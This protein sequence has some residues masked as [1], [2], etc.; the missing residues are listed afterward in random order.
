MINQKQKIKAFTLSELIIVILITV[1]VAGIAF[2]VLRLV[3][4]QMYGIQTNFQHTTNVSL[5]EQSLYLDAHRSNRMQYDDLE[6]TLHFISEIDTVR[7]TF[8]KNLV[9]K[10]IDTFHITIDKAQFY[11]E[12]V[13]ATSHRMDAFKLTTAKEFKNATI[14]I[15]KRNSATMYMNP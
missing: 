3:Q 1:I 6:N 13:E 8:E 5:L 15:Y 4:K 7:Y 14:F 10:E 9:R 11:F 12:G 2:S